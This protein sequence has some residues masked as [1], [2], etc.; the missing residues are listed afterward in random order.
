VINI[1]EKNTGPLCVKSAIY[2]VFRLKTAI[3][4]TGVHE[5]HATV[6]EWQMHG[7][8]CVNYRGTAWAR[9]GMCELPRHGMGTALQVR[10]S[11][12]CGP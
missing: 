12:Y 7:M 10:I 11:F 6:G 4:I 2:V 3:C 5:G 9:H 1:E 8:A